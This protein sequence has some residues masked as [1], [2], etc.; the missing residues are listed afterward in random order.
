MRALASFTLQRK[1]RTNLCRTQL[2]DY[3]PQPGCSGR[4]AGCVSGRSTF[5]LPST[6][7]EAGWL[8]Y[9]RTDKKSIIIY[10]CDF[11]RSHSE[12][13]LATYCMP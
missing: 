7:F 11:D 6:Y 13:Y 9:I 4:R 2:L 1:L 12:N 10:L 3:S 5:V 8:A